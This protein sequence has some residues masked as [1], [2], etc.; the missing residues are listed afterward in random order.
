M[1]GRTIIQVKML[2]D[3]N[4]V[5]DL[6]GQISRS[7]A[8]SK[9]SLKIMG[10]ICWSNCWS[11]SRIKFTGR[12][13]R[14]NPEIKFLDQIPRSNCW[15][16]AGNPWPDAGQPRRTHGHAYGRAENGQGREGKR[17][18][19]GHALRAWPVVVGVR[20]C[21]SVVGGWCRNTLGM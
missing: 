3:H 14:S 7:N 21:G 18:R 8:G 15:S 13:A 19:K 17:Q 5:A 1:R 10:R 12:I 11:N 4:P 2:H 6:L 20:A 16:N 9:L